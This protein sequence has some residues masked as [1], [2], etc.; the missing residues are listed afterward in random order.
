[1]GRFD[2]PAAADWSYAPEDDAADLDA[3]PGQPMSHALT[4]NAITEDRPEGPELSAH[5]AYAAELLTEEQVQDLARTWFR[6][7]E[8]VVQ[9]AAVLNKP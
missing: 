1:M 8:A 3:D 9:R 4:L 6:A 2:R 5:W 7:L